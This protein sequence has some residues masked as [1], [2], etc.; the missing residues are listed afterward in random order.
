M[1]PGWTALQGKLTPQRKGVIT[2]IYYL[3]TWFSYV[4]I[5][6]PLSDSYGRR[7]AAMSGTAILC[8]GALLQAGC[9]GPTPFTM[10][11]VGRA[12]CG[13]GVAIVSTSVPLYQR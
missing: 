5:S 9:S 7:R 10:M 11:V 8:A 12:I 6:R 13:I 2:G 1:H 4:F 3:G